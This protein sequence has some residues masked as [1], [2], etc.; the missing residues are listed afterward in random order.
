MKKEKL[1]IQTIKW[2]ELKLL[3][4]EVCDDYICLCNCFRISRNEY[5]KQL[6]ENP[7]TFKH[8]YACAEYRI[9]TD[10]GSI[11]LDNIHKLKAKIDE[12]E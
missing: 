9:L 8:G 2:N 5:D 1:T 4:N 6:R 10:N 12:L 11:L 3:I 7:G